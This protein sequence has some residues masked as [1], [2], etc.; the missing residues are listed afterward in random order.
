MEELI[1][2]MEHIEQLLKAVRNTVEPLSR[3]KRLGQ[4]QRINF[5]R[6]DLL[7]KEYGLIGDYKKAR[8]Q[9]VNGI[10][11]ILHELARLENEYGDLAIDIRRQAIV[12]KA[13]WTAATNIKKQT[14]LLEPLLLDLEANCRVLFQGQEQL[15]RL[16]SLP[17]LLPSAKKDSKLEPEEL[18]QGLRFFLFVTREEGRSDTPSLALCQAKA[19]ELERKFKSLEFSGLPPMAQNLLE[20]HRLTAVTAADHL[21]AFIEQF[22]QSPP[23]EVK[24]LEAFRQHLKELR[25]SEAL[26][27]L[28][29][30]PRVSARYGGILF[31]L[32]HRARN[33]RQVTMIAPFLDKLELLHHTLAQELPG[34][35][36]EQLDDSASPLNPGRLAASQAADFFMGLRGVMLSFKMLFSSLGGQKAVTA[37]ELQQI[38]IDALNR[39][40][41]HNDQGQQRR[42]QL[43]LFL[44]ESLSD[45]AKPFPFE[46]LAEHLEKNIKILGRRLERFIEQHPTGKAGGSMTADEAGNGNPTLGQLTAKLERW[47]E[48]LE[49]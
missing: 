32:A 33:L 42:Q 7:F 34:R 23:H 27:L 39:C 43:N 30:L 18:D 2:E 35:L 49:G 25:H 31:D 12:P 21:K 36:K 29:E 37:P 24:T 6:H 4:W 10:R 47:S 45:Y 13:A 17:G 9:T 28:E 1:S 44:E 48:R 26:K 16:F 14:E 41:V 15:L 11:T 22:R 5:D 19:T 38:T 40:P 3:D 20:Q 46:L 8:D